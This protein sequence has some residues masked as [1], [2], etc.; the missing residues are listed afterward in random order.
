MRVQHIENAVKGLLQT[1][2]FAGLPQ[3]FEG[4]AKSLRWNV[5]HGKVMTAATLLKVAALR[6]WNGGM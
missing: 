6:R 5:W 2:D 4:P 3:L 1:Q